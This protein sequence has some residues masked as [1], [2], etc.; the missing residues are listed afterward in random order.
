[1]ALL[2]RII[3][4]H[5]PHDCGVYCISRGG[6]GVVPY[7]S[8]DDEGHVY[9]NN[10][11]LPRAGSDELVDG[12]GYCEIRTFGSGGPG[13]PCQGEDDVCEDDVAL[14]WTGS[15]EPVHSVVRTSGSGGPCDEEVDVSEGNIAMHRTG[16]DETV[17]RVVGTISPG[18]PGDETGSLADAPRDAIAMLSECW[19]SD[20]GTLDNIHRWRVNPRSESR[21]CCEPSHGFRAIHAIFSH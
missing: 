18:G 14:P 13:G 11:A 1:M 4:L 3:E 7:W 6:V 5:G 12:L 21:V 2:G 16:S 9:E 10:V 8:G 17:V 19:D 20:Q 15:D